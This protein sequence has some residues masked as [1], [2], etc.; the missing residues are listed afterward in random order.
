MRRNLRAQ[1]IEQCLE[2]A[3]GLILEFVERIALRIAPEADDRPEVLNRHKV[4]APLLVKRV[5]ENLLFQ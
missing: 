3:E 2:Q 4:L 1:R 5:Q